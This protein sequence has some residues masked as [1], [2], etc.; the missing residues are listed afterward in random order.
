MLF[1]LVQEKVLVSVLEACFIM[2]KID[3]KGYDSGA[4]LPQL[5]GAFKHKAE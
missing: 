3:K 4:S 2:E 1:V 5:M